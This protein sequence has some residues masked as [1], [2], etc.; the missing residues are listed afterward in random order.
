MTTTNAYTLGTTYV[1]ADERETFIWELYPVT[2]APK[3]Q[4]KS[5]L[6]TL[7]ETTYTLQTANANLELFIQQVHADKDF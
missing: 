7:Q 4:W 1:P 5:R 2:E 3:E 6:S